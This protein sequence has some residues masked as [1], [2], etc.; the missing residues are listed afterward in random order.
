MLSVGLLSPSA[1]RNAQHHFAALLV[2]DGI[3]ILMEKISEIYHPSK[4]PSPSSI[5]AEN[6][7]EEDLRPVESATYAGI[8]NLPPTP[9]PIKNTG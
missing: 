1:P 6:K 7:P 9:P 2:K 5:C 8:P 4:F 3:L